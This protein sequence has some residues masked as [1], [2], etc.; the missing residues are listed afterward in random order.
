LKAATRF[1]IFLSH[2]SSA[3]DRE[4]IF[5]L[6]TLL[7]RRKFDVYMAEFDVQPGKRILDKVE[8]NLKAC[9]AVVVVITPNSSRSQWVLF[10]LGM[11]NLSRLPVIPLVQFGTEVPKP[12]A[13]IE[14]VAF[15]REDPK[16]SFDVVVRH[17][18]TLRDQWQ[19]IQGY[20][21]LAMVGGLLAGLK[22]LDYLDERS[23]K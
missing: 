8:K 14:Y 4:I 21:E 7:R 6:R 1:R 10:E 12:L 11:A 2:S 16:I 5:E 18:N 23:R 15:E 13:G 17:M 19:R 20:K 22:L 3:E 9:Q